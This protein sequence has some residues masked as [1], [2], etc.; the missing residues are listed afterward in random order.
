MGSIL[1]DK[2]GFI[3]CDKCH[4][5]HYWY[6]LTPTPFLSQFINKLLGWRKTV[7]LCF[8]CG[9]NFQAIYGRKVSK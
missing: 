5:K 2:Q 4:K 6:K 3:L 1:K 8:W 7:Y 9:A